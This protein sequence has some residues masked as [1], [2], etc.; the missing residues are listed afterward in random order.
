MERF[1]GFAADGADEIVGE[2]LRADVRNI[3]VRVFRKDL[4]LDRGEKMGLAQTARSVDKKR[5][6][7]AVLFFGNRKAR[8]T[9]RI[10]K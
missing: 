9:A 6:V 2:G 5:I 1:G 3:D 7:L 4:V 10:L 8:V